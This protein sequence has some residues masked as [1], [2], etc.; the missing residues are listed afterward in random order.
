[1]DKMK[2]IVALIG[3]VMFSFSY[4]KYV[5]TFE[6]VHTIADPNE[7][8]DEVTTETVKIGDQEWMIDNLNVSKFR[9]G[10]LIRQ[11]E[12]NE[13]WIKA[14]IEGIPAWCY[15][16]NNPENGEKYGKL[17][18]WYAVNDTIR[19][20]IAPEGWHIPS[21]EE[22][23]QLVDYLDG[24]ELAALK[25]KSDHG[26]LYDGNGNNESGFTGLPGGLRLPNGD[27]ISAGLFGIWWSSSEYSAA[28]AWSRTLYYNDVVITSNHHR[29][30]G[31][32]VRLLKD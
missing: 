23:K 20:G 32:S 29:A 22:W 17:Y 9:N 25:M 8:Y 11:A 4:G 16:E 30:N 19:G 24:R 12:S 5:S 6:I 18:N 31:I 26:W 10:E 1:M 15:Y 14:Y 2:L 3:V 28:N 13:E 27:F 21:N 7:S